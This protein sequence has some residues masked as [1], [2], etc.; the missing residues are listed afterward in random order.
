[1]RRLI[2]VERQGAH[3]IKI[4]DLPKPNGITII[5][6]CRGIF[7]D[8]TGKDPGLQAPKILTTTIRKIT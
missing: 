8:T 3:K 1:M 4:K 2:P 7:P 5:C 6:D